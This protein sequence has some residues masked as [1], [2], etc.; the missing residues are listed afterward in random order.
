MKRVLVAGYT[1]NNLGD[2]L[3]F[4]LLVKRYPTTHFTF[5]AGSES[6]ILQT[7]KN[8]DIEQLRL[9]DLFINIRKFN[10]FV[11]I[12]GS[13]FQQVR[14][15]PWIKRWLVLFLKVLLFKLTGKKIVFIGFN[16]GPYYSKSFYIFYKLLFSAVNYL[17]V[18]DKKTFELFKTNSRVHLFP[19]IVFSLEDHDFCKPKKNS[20]GISVMDFGPNI[21]FQQEYEN[22]LVEIINGINS[23]ISITLYGFQ[24]APS[25]NDS[26]VIERVKN[27]LHRSVRS[28][29]YNGINKT[30]F[31]ED[32]YKNFFAITSRFHSL[33]L[34]LKARQQII[35]I[36]YNLK[37]SSLLN[38]LSINNMDI[39]IEEFNN[40]EVVR[41]IVSK[42]N[43][44]T[45]SD[46]T[47]ISAEEI[48]RLT[49][50][51]TAHFSYLDNLLGIKYEKNNV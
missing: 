24:S 48:K 17:S 4:S 20:L 36:D 26:V 34:S 10:M 30:L 49:D 29:C 19:D 46:N 31:L 8:V 15:Q 44:A 51:A 35:S 9:K 12:G 21:R 6:Q 11:L 42:I 32:Y 16:F 2:D 45:I 38:T 37:V 5:E 50:Q 39:Q 23:S 41:N 25:I 22:F 13:M 47:Y 3:F 28:V 40:E 1:S 27:R 18:R 43:T 7:F 14:G 33:I